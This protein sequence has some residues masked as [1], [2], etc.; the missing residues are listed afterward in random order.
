MIRIQNYYEGELI[1]NGDYFFTTKENSENHGYGLKS[2]KYSVNR[3]GGV[4]K[5][6]AD[7]H[8]FEVKILIPIRFN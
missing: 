5:V 4:L 1:E 7:N 3:Y 2:I 8:W 6:M